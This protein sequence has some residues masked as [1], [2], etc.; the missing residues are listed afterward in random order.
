MSYNKWDKDLNDSVKAFEGIRKTILPKIISGEILTIESAENDVLIKLDQKSGIDYIRE[1]KTGMQGIAARA[2]WG[3]AWNTFT[4][5]KER[6]TG[7]KTE[8]EKRKEQIE[9]GYFYPAFT[10]QAYFDNRTNNSL[11]SIAIIK[12]KS[13]FEFIENNPE[14]ILQR[15][16][17]NLFIAIEW[18]HINNLIKTSE[19]QNNKP[20][21]LRL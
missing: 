2:Q 11:L 16:S 7:A 14:K 3:K 4:I 8:L 1:D 21:Q 5:R 9:K 13:L 12:T 6:H 20:K 17:D 18:I 10:M 19:L 15:K